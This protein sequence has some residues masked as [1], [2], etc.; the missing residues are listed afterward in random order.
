MEAFNMIDQ[1]RGGEIT[2]DELRVSMTEADVGITKQTMDL[3]FKKVR[4]LHG[5]KFAVECRPK[6]RYNMA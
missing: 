1:D 2:L 3:M 6:F 4:N 5:H